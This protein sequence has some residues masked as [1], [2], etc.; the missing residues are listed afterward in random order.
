MRSGDMSL[1]RGSARARLKKKKVAV[2][3]AAQVM[4]V[5][6]HSCERASTT[7]CAH[8]QPFA[9]IRKTPMNTQQNTPSSS[10]SSAPSNT[11]VHFTAQQHAARINT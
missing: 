9:N 4:R 11:S 3:I 1:C 8:M 10:V 5:A 2:H 6:R 7:Q